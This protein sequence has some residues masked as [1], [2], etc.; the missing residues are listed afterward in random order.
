MASQV[1]AIGSRGVEPVRPSEADT[2][3]GG[4]NVGAD[5]PR[6]FLL[7]IDLVTLLVTFELSYVLAPVAKRMALA[8]P[9]MAGAVAVLS[10]Q[11]G[12]EYRP[13]NEVLWVLLILAPATVLCLQATGAYRPILLQS[14]TRIV[15]STLVS[16]LVG[17]GA[18]TVVLFTLR[19]PSWS[20][21]FI[22]S[23]TLFGAV[24]LCAYR[25]TLRSYRA[26]RVASGFYARNVVLIGP[27]ASLVW[28]AEHLAQTMSREQFRV[29]GYLAVRQQQPVS[30]T[31]GLAS[32]GRVEDFG[33]LLVHQPIHEVIAIQGDSAS[34]WLTP[35]VESCDYFRITLRIVPEALLMGHLRDLEF[36]YH[37]DPLKLPEV[38][39]RPRDFD[40]D[41]LFVKRLMDIAVSGVLLI[42]LSPLF[43]L[44]ALAIKLSTPGLTIFYLWQVVGFKGRRFT[45]YKFSTMVADADQRRGDLLDRNEMQGPVFKIKED[46][47]VTP[48]GRFLRKYSL[49]E[50]PQLWSVLRGDMSLVGP[51]PAFPHELERY[52]LWHKRKLCVRP[53]ITCLWQVRGRNRITDFD[54][55]VRMDLEYIDK[56]SLWLDLK[57][58]GRTAWAVVA[59]TGS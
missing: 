27:T 5:I 1:T 2:L 13:L 54:E 9:A 4:G 41:A 45:G 57:I 49:N 37:S 18:V 36:L 23:F 31:A 11:L 17:L 29:L 40:S 39:L 30:E 8:S 14:R 25:L 56:W 32:L 7:L 51:R 35:V 43:L 53:G 6:V 28:M 26:R 42:V 16:P 58:L 33:S 34:E 24:S 12:G 3:G 21:L 52:E 20:R 38:V 50:L 55:W 47:R 10:P 59:G 48:V 15:V 44:I 46:P 22:F 19:S